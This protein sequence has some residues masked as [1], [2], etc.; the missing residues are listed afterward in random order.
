MESPAP[1]VQEMFQQMLA[2]QQSM[3][4]SF[5]DLANGSIA[6]NTKLD[7]ISKSFENIEFITNNGPVKCFESEVL[8]NQQ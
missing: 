6:T 4:D 7:A 8:T 2:F 5:R 1:T 3:T